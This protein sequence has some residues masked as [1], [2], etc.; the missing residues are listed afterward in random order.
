MLVQLGVAVTELRNQG[1][2]VRVRGFI[3]IQGEEDTKNASVANR[4]GNNL[5]TLMYKVRNKTIALN[6][7]GGFGNTEFRAVIGFNEGYGGGNYHTEVVQKAQQQESCHEEKRHAFASTQVYPGH[8]Y[9][10][11]SRA[12]SPG[13]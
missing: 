1:Y 11:G 2:R 4:Y 7:Q 6:N 8:P 12:C 3:W 5:N 10:S 13:G 9:R